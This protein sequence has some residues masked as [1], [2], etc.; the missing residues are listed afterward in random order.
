MQPLTEDYPE[1]A[2]L[3]GLFPDAQ[4]ALWVNRQAKSGV[5]CHFLLSLILPGFLAQAYGESS[6]QISL[7][8][9]PFNRSNC[10]R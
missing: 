4:E 9:K 7:I 8:A 5:H 6:L 1:H 10:R 2:T 3:I